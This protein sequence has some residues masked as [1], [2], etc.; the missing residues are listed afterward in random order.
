MCLEFTFFCPYRTSEYIEKVFIHI[1]EK[2]PYK[3]MYMFTNSTLL[4][5]GKIGTFPR[6]FIFP[7]HNFFVGVWESKNQYDFYN[8][9]IVIKFLLDFFFYI[10]GLFV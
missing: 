7:T 3:N 1:T 6:I 8:I 4:T 10:K 9:P 2:K 5:L